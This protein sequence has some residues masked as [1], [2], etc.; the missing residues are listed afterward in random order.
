MKR[1]LFALGLVATSQLVGCLVGDTTATLSDDLTFEEFRE[2]TFKEPWDDGAYIID[3]DTAVPND[4]ALYE[5]WLALYGG[6]ELIVNTSG[7]LDT[8]WNDTQK[9]NL[10]Y[11]VSNNF[12]GNK[13]AV[14]EA[15][16]QATDL[17]WE[18]RGNVNFVYASAQDANCTASNTNVVFD[19]RPVNVGGQYL[20][21]AFFPNNARSS[22]NVLIDNTAF[23]PG[24]T[25]PL[26]NI[27]AHE[28]GHALGFRHEHTRPESGACFE[29]NS[30]RPLTP[31]D[32][33]SVMH[34]PQCN[35]T[36]SN[37]AFTAR[38]AEGVAALYGAPG[39][40]NPPPPPPPPPPTGGTQTWS[41]SVTLN[42]FKIVGGP[43]AVR[44]GSTL[45]VVMTGS[46]DAD[47]YVRF[48]SAPTRSRFAC[49]PYT[50]S[51]NES[52]TL[53]VP[54]GATSFYVG[55][56]GYQASSYNI[57]ATYTAP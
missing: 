14:V 39:G 55:V 23:D 37:L 16:R 45:S 15:L 36:S 41:G 4:K 35:G 11:C 46:A 2:L 21:R 44:V 18:V 50:A 19:V 30:W 7:G 40:G 53:T 12:G 29:D 34:Y 13:A 25:W 33:A 49:R 57:T 56:D 28:L 43:I 22:R 51:G 17:G 9:L 20:A 27:L 24:L 5:E 32:S 8:K 47:L 52:C 48:N 10:T 54:S 31:Y 26:K 3:G 1:S 42:Q 6:Q 38:D